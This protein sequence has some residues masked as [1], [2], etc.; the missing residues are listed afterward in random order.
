M[1]EMYANYLSG[2]KTPC[3]DIESRNRSESLQSGH[4]RK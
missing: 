2:M 3:L 4:F 1:N